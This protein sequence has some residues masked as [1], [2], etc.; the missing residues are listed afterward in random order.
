MK[1]TTF[2][3]TLSIGILF[4]ACKNQTT[5]KLSEEQIWKL[6]WRMIEN[7]FKEKDLVA[8]AQFD[9]LLLV[10]KK[11]DKNF[12]ITGLETKSKF[13]RKSEISSVLN[14]Q[15]E[16]ML[17]QICAQQFLADFEVCANWKEEKV[18]NKP[19]QKELIQ[20]FVNDQ[21]VRGKKMTELIS[22]YAIDPSQIISTDGPTVD[23]TNRKRLNEIIQEVGFPTRQLV[24]KDAVQ[25]AF[26]I[27]QHADRDKDWQKA[28]LP[29]IEN[30]VKKG[31]LD[32][33]RYAYLY[34]RIQVN[35]GAK[36]VYGTQFEKIDRANKTV[37]LSA[38][39][40]SVNLDKR[41]RTI[42]MMPIDMYKKLV[43]QDL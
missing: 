39:E 27:I 24:G 33:Q 40:D 4:F 37:Q 42:G 3:L 22:K 34:D 30:A 8:E 7:S 17:Q 36:Q 26:Y 2:F 38:V 28:Q 41:R 29:H 1:N 32:G 5:P 43:L 11:L 19:L 13:G 6:G 23:A 31:D 20:M 9:S 12:L 21:A 35:S 10:T 18:E 16:E 15:N 14:A 25:G